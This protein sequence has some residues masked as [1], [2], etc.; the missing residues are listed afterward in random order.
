MP[1]KQVI[2]VNK[3]LKMSGGK[4]G[5]QVSH[6]S[7][8]FLTTMIQ[9]NAGKVLINGIVRDD[10]GKKMSKSSNNG[11]DPIEIIEKYGA[12]ALRFS[13]LLGNGTGGLAAE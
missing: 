10:E 5:A 13:L 3:D 2:V 12:D 11:V 7:M 8:A 6:A 9:N 4:L 1:I